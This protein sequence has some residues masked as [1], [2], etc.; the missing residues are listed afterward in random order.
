MEKTQIAATARTGIA[1]YQQPPPQVPLGRKNE[2][3][4]KNLKRK[5]SEVLTTTTAKMKTEK[6]IK[7]LR[8]HLERNTCPKPLKYS[9]QAKIP[10][11]QQ[12]KKDIN[13]I[14]QKTKRGFVEA[15]SF[16]TVGLRNR[17]RNSIRNGSKN[18]DVCTTEDRNKIKALALKLKEQYDY[19]MSKLSDTGNKNCEKYL[20]V[21][22]KCVY[23]TVGG[24][25]KIKEKSF[26]RKIQRKTATHKEGRKK[27]VVKTLKGKSILR[28]SQTGHKLMPKLV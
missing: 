15:K 6:S 4:K 9:G 16:T 8:N 1:S 24:S 14:K 2:A 5:G 17:S 25:N 21:S 18:V 20:Q 23:N 10:G 22:V 3:K 12:F 28:T 27:S 13:A 19:L 7:Q 11:D 26:C